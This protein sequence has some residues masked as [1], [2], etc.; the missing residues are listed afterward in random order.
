MTDKATG[1]SFPSKLMGM[2][3]CGVGC[4]KKG[5]IKVYS[6]GMYASGLQDRLSAL[7]A[8]GAAALAALRK[9]AGVEDPTTFLLEMNF[10]VGAEK[11]ASA[12]AEGVAPRHKG[13]ASDVDELKDLIFN[14]VAKKG[15]AT[16][17]TTFQFDCTTS[18]VDVS[19]DG[20]KQGNVASAGLSSA[21]CDIYLDD[22]TVS[23][24]LRKSCIE[25]FCMP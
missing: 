2:P 18:G 17:G 10:K 1:I 4:R 25:K 11:M 19:V 16:K 7:S 22:K 21:F 13:A 12:I 20:K 8:S 6:V 5:P 9:G 15:A 24:P 23:P 14:G 3:I